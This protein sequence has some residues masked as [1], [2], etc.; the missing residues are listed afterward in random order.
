MRDVL[1]LLSKRDLRGLGLDD[2]YK[3]L[4]TPFEVMDQAYKEDLGSEITEELAAADKLRDDAIF[5]IKRHFEGYAVDDRPEFK[6]AGAR[7]LRNIN[8]Y[9]PNI[10]RQ[11][12]PAQTTTT[13]SLTNGWEGQFATDITQVNLAYQAKRVKTTNVAF[14]ELYLLRVE[15][16]GTLADIDMRGLRWE[17]IHI[18]REISRLIYA[19]D[20][21]GENPEYGVIQGIIKELIQKYNQMIVN[22]KGSSGASGEEVSDLEFDDVEE[23]DGLG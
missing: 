20:V 6:A 4:Q 22:R 14:E 17:T 8:R 21:I 9:G 3:K 13:W 5:C 2:L 10:Q 12:Y 7:L 1:N 23:S 15:E 19:Y 11:P 16:R 18:Y